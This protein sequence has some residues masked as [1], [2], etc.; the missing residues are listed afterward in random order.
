M[1]AQLQ[2]LFQFLGDSNPQVRQ[3]ALSSLV[4]QTP[5]DSPYRHIFFDGLTPP[6]ETN[7]IRDLKLMC[8]DQ[9]D[10]AHDAFRAL[11]NLSESPLL[12]SSMTESSFLVFL[13][14]YI[15]NPDAILADLASMI[16]SNITGSSSAC[17]V[18]LRLKIPLIPRTSSVP[19]L[20]FYT[21]QSRSGT[22]PA[23]VPYPSAESQEALALPLLIDAFVHGAPIQQSENDCKRMRKAELHFLSGVFANIT[24]SLAGRLFFVTPWPADPLQTNGALLY[25]LAK[26]LA[27]TEHQDIV[28]RRG[29]ISTL[30]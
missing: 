30:K 28:R 10:I 24:G 9:P 6:R 18:L 2:E 27:F 4:G 29:T 23:P 12:V 1:E 16:L 26:I 14:S 15:L 22:C 7:V 25:P 21:P 19:Q 17:S 20:S 3:I 13:V 11:V 8:R 5:R